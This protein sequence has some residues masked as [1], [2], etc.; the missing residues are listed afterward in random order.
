[1]DKPECIGDGRP[2][3]Y[4]DL[5]DP[6]IAMDKLEIDAPPFPVSP[7]MTTL[8]LQL[9]LLQA[10][11]DHAVAMNVFHD[12]EDDCLRTVGYRRRAGSSG[13]DYYEL[14]PA[15]ACLA[16]EVLAE[17]R[18]RIGCTEGTGDGTLR[19]RHQSRVLTLRAIVPDSSEVRLYFTDD[20]PPMRT[21]GKRECGE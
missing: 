6:E 15:P 14:L 7:E 10:I 16:A 19:L 11:K 1:M 2:E 9:V 3:L 21:K 5:D 4:I 17:L 12:A 8:F 20:R 13:F 18:R